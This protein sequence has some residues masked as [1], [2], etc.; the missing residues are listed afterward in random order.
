MFLFF[1]HDGVMFARSWVM[2]I[3]MSEV[4]F[5]YDL[6]HL[7]DLAGCHSCGNT[8]KTSTSNCLLRKPEQDSWKSWNRLKP[9][10]CSATVS[11]SKK[12]VTVWYHFLNIHLTIIM[13]IFFGLCLILFR[14]YANRDSPVSSPKL[15]NTTDYYMVMPKIPEISEMKIMNEHDTKP[16]MQ[17]W[18]L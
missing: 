9:P 2:P 10:Q 4:H 1:L 6:D 7:M 13:R 5:L 16:C 18:H 15:E 17:Q 3:V 8:S 11:G 14:H 12:L